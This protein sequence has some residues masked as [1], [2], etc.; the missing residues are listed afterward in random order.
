MKLPVLILKLVTIISLVL[1]VMSCEKACKEQTN[2]GSICLTV[3]EPVCGCNNKTYS[4]S[5]NA[6]AYGIDEFTDGECPK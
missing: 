3:Y 4:N 2:D 5:C 6:N 1:G